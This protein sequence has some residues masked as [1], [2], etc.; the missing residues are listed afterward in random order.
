MSE[1]HNLSDSHLRKVSYLR[2]SVTDR[3]NLHCVYCRGNAKECFLPHADIL[4]FEEIIRLVQIMWN[5]GVRKVRL[6]GG[7]PFARKGCAD[8]A[9]SLRKAFPSLNLR[10]TSNGTLLRPYIS[11]LKAAAVNAINLSID[12]FQRSTFA[13]ITGSDLLDEVLATFHLLIDMGIRVKINTVAM[14]GVNDNE[15]EDFIRVIKDYPVDLRFI[16]FMPMGRGTIWNKSLF[17]PADDILMEA[18]KY[19][20]LT[21]DQDTESDHGPARM[22]K[23]DG[24]KGRI[25]VISALS[26]HFCNTCNRLRITSDGHLRTCLF[27]DKMYPLREM[28]RDPTVSD[29]LIAQAIRTALAEKPIGV[30]L[31]KARQS[32]AVAKGQ[33][34][35]IGG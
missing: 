22:Y 23:L 20:R 14:R 30:E 4:R 15:M 5:F 34:D 7:E 17:W 1:G 12:S 28:L 19:A 2:F 9:V 24:C 8:L 13:R 21:P 31:L 25:G 32:V 10:L 6:T 26:N 18:R 16:E 3:C 29:D 11:T 27:A 33:M 35:T